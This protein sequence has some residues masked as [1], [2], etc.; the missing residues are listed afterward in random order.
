VTDPPATDPPADADRRP[1]AKGSMLAELIAE[2]TARRDAERRLSQFESN[3][4][5]QRLTPEVQ[6]AI[7]EG[8]V[9]IAAPEATRAAEQE[10]LRSVAE[11]LQLYKLDANG[12]HVP[13]LD[14]A[15]RVSQFVRSEVQAEVA[16]VRQMSLAEKARVNVD[17]AVAY[18]SQH[19]LDVDIVKDEFLTILTQPNG[20][21]MLS[22]AK[23]AK[24]VWRVAVG[25]M[26]EEGK[27]TAK[28][29]KKAAAAVPATTTPAAIIS[30]PTGR[31]ASAASAITLSPGLQ[32][33][34][35]EHGVNPAKSFTA[36]RPSLNLHGPIDLE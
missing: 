28:E 8:R 6:Q 20:P 32:R 13:D 3:P 15:K 18:A 2:R 26:H 33:V 27:L 4:V 29:A 24:Q 11:T 34:Y 9:Q 17:K 30:E 14:A 23:I 21:E 36:S 19:G 7:L 5:L 35:A 12:Q 22:D 1:A 16:P 10:R 31:R 25:R